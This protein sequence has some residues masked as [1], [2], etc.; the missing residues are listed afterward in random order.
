MHSAII[1]RSRVA[2]VERIYSKTLHLSR[3][4]I[5]LLVVDC[6]QY[7][8]IVSLTESHI[9]FNG[10]TDM[11]IN[12][13]CI[14]KWLTSCTSGYNT[15]RTRYITTRTRYNTARTRYIT[16]RTRYSTTRTRYNTTKTRNKTRYNTALQQNHCNLFDGWWLTNSSRLIAG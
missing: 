6:V 7:W 3:R 9:V 11:E 16:P 13:L 10:T 8:F 2:C 5:I 15:A 12:Y 4:S 1:F 14:M